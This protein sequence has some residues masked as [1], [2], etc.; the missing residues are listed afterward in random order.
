MKSDSGSSTGIKGRSIEPGSLKEGIR[1]E[2]V[3]V[4]NITSAAKKSE[5]VKLG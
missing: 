1:T 2:A 4:A 3:K 5:R